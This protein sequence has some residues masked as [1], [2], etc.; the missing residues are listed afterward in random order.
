MS[1]LLITGGTGFIGEPAARLARA[2]FEVHVAARG[3]RAKPQATYHCCDLLEPGA[4][5]QLIATVRPTH[6]LH[7]AWTATPGTF[8]TDPRNE[9]W[10]TASRHLLTAFAQCGGRRAVTVGSC[11]EYDWTA[12]GVCREAD[13][14]TNP[15]TPYGRAKLA[16]GKWA[17]GF[18]RLRDVSVAHARLFWM[19]GPNEHP[20]RLVPTVARALLAGVPAPCTAGAQR[21][22]FLHVDDV[23]G[24]LVAVLRSDLTGAV[25]VGSG[26]A[27]A[28]RDVIGHVARACGRPELV[29]FGARDTAPT[30]PPLIVADVSRLR[31]ELG[32]G[33]TTDLASGLED[34]VAWWRATGTE[35][36]TKCA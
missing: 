1:R 28:V 18:G 29:K 11:A 24:A 10:A 14:P 7:L 16:F 20:D 25:N 30:D 23:A 12:G 31:T 21:R 32:W 33:P 17:V 6:L 36:A 15:H 22:D 26:E 35:G 2:H 27:V 5:Y 19:Y 4:A 13:T 3:A 9:D 8:W 34:T